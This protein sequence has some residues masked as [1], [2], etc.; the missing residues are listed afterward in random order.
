MIT[1]TFFSGWDFLMGLGKAHLPANL[2]VANFSRS[3]NIKGKTKFWR[4]P[5]AHFSSWCNFMMGFGKPKLRTKFEV[6]CFSRC[7]NIKK[8]LQNFWGVPLAHGHAFFSF[9]FSWC[10]FMLALGKLKLKYR[11]QMWYAKDGK[12]QGPS[13]SHTQ[14][15]K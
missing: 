7:K 4:A 10:D 2:K 6:A 1:P 8:E 9:G 5:L 14:R 11:L 3:R 15:S 12:D 13:E